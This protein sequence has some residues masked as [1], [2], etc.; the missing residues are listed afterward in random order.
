ML[1][2]VYSDG[3]GY[4][5]MVNRLKKIIE[6]WNIPF[7]AY[8]RNYVTHLAHYETCESFRK[9]MSYPKGGGY[10]AWKPLIM[11][12]SLLFSDEVI[13]LDSSVI[14]KSP[15]TLQS[16]MN[17]TKKITAVRTTYINKDWTKR[18]C[19][20]EM[21]CDKQRYWNVHQ[22][23][24]A[25]VAVRNQRRL[26]GMTVLQKWLNYCSDY[27]VVSDIPCAG[28]FQGFIQHRHDQS[29][30]TNLLVKYKQASYV[31]S[32]FIDDVRYG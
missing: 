24:G 22:I 16:L 7:R 32:D 11:Q 3:P 19:F 21:N 2:I 30:L 15:E 13:Y 17:S 10:W 29:I 18:S 1:V 27:D 8:D 23:W 28:N 6:S 14:P 9:V 4:L 26:S 12:H 20:V 31:S 25:V 5:F